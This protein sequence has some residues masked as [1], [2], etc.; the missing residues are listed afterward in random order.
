M[1]FD[2]D[3]AEPLTDKGGFNP[4][5]AEPWTE[6]ASFNPD[7]AEAWKDPAPKPKKQ[8]YEVGEEAP[9]MEPGEAA[10]M[11]DTFRG[12]GTEGSFA[13]RRLT[14]AL[15]DTM[16]PRVTLPEAP[17]G[18]PE[19]TM[20]G[21]VLPMDVEAGVYNAAKGAPEAL[22]APIG[23][24]L[25]PLQ[26]V[27]GGSVAAQVI[28]KAAEVYFA[29][30]MAQ[31]GG[32]EA[33]E[34]VEAMKDP[35][36]SRQE[37]LEAGGRAV[38]SLGLATG[39]AAHAGAPEHGALVETAGEASGEARMPTIEP[40]GPKAPKESFNPD[41]AEPLKSV[42]PIKVSPDLNAA[43]ETAAEASFNPETAKPLK[44][45]NPLA[46]FNRYQQ[47]D[48]RMRE[49]V[50][51]GETQT[52]EFR[53]LWRENEDIKNRNSSDRGNPPEA[54]E[55]PKTERQAELLND[56]T[57]FNLAGAEETAP[58]EVA[59][60][61]QAELL[62][63]G[64]GR[65]MAPTAMD[66]RNA[67]AREQP[68]EP[69]EL[70]MSGET[71]PPVG[72][73]LTAVDR[74][75]MRAE[76]GNGTPD[77]GPE[78]L[79]WI[80][81]KLPRPEDE[82]TLNGE[83][84]GIWDNLLKEREVAEKKANVEDKR[85]RKGFKQTDAGEATRF[86]AKKGG[87]ADLDRLR[88]AANEAGFNFETPADMLAAVDASMRGN[89]IYANAGE[90]GGSPIAHQEG[91]A[92]NVPKSEGK[93]LDA[94]KSRADAARERLTKKFKSGRV[95]AGI[96]PTDLKDMAEIGA[97]HLARGVTDAAQ[98]SAAMIKEFGEKI[99]P[100]LPIIRKAAEKTHA[101]SDPSAATNYGIAARV[102]A[103]R[104]EGGH[105]APVEPGLVSEPEQIV[106]RG[107]MLLESGHDPVE[108][109]QRFHQ[110]KA[111][112]ADDI[113]IVRA[114][115]EELA[116]AANTA[117]DKHGV[118][119]AEYDAAAKADSDWVAAIKPMQTAWAE[120]GRAQQGETEIDTGTFHGLRRS[121][122]EDTGK[123]FTPKQAGEAIKVARKVKDATDA[124]DAASKEL[125][126][127]IKKETAKLPKGEPSPE[128]FSLAERISI[129]LEK[130]GDAALARIK[131]RLNG[132]LF[133]TPLDPE[134]AA[135]MI[136]LGTSKIAKG[137]LDFARW[138]AE[139]VRDVG[140]GIKPHLKELWDKANREIDRE[141]SRIVK[142]ERRSAVK[143]ALTRPREERKAKA[144]GFK[145]S[146]LI[147]EKGNLQEESRQIG[148]PGVEQRPLT[149]DNPLRQTGE[150]VG[151]AEEQGKQAALPG[152]E[153]PAVRPDVATRRAGEVVGDAREQA[154]QTKLPIK[155]AR[156]TP[157]D[158]WSLAKQYIDEG[159]T[160]FESMRHKIA[161]D[162][163]IP[164]EEVTHE[165]A[166]PKDLARMTNEMYEKLS[167]RRNA[168]DDA[169]NFLKEQ[170]TPGWE[171]VIRA[172][173]RVF[174]A[175]K[176]FGHG[177]VGMITHAGLNIFDPTAWRVYW[178]NFFRQ[179]KLLGW[180]DKGAFHERMMQDLVRDENFTLARRSGLANDPR[181]Y[182]DDY[183]STWLGKYLNRIGLTG[184]RGFD[185]LKLYRQ[186]RF[187]QIWDQMPDSLK[188]PDMAKLI[189]DEV[190]HATGVVRMR[191]R[192]WANWTFFAPKLE[193]SR[194]AWMVG[195]P[196]KAA[197]VLGNW[198]DATP[199]EK[200]FAMREVRQKAIIAGTYIGLLAANQ[201][202]L[203]MVG[204][205]QSINYTNP[206]RGDFL[207]FKVGGYNF[208]VVGPMLG[209]VRLFANL[210]H[211]SFG[212]RTPFEQAAASRSGQSAKVA[213]DY[214]R[215]KLSPFASF[216]ED[217]RTQA[218]FR[219][220]P[221]PFSKERVPASLRRQGIGAY[222][223]GEYAAEQFS[224]IPVSEAVKEIWA[225]QGMDESTAEHW[226]D[227]LV[228][229][230]VMGST[231]AKMS[232]DA[233]I[234]EPASPPPRSP[235][236]LHRRGH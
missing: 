13:Q 99:K 217:M 229:A 210:L 231:G 106:E 34:F 115:G 207:A 146:S 209:M 140:A 124:A 94:L 100:Y 71:L 137:T 63:E 139:M 54:P 212:T 236:M 110:T 41:T 114:H 192:E 119:S 44:A 164:V 90:E 126:E 129:A 225:K 64:E 161:A 127:G 111:L 186:A 226:M 87:K 93:I 145:V 25:A 36:K 91:D 228:A 75:R 116:K 200:M 96:D 162:L 134:L 46:D 155:E 42:E 185:A 53:D 202:L 223:Y 33:A 60:E 219:G 12:R 216:A 183:Q 113:A 32:K 82:S 188:N 166:R 153:R 5:T 35:T 125:I 152:I 11:K 65:S 189:A 182:T 149:P 19:V 157:A 175:A 7:T 213:G 57:P 1:P 2:P 29:G 20:P 47:I 105:I 80:K 62:P 205:K 38:V 9:G 181:R 84:Q 37:R 232:K 168:V 148:L 83:L 73:P 150:V 131:E 89:K 191:F 187:N 59:P 95:S 17:T 158:V 174:F 69:L 45:E 122:I 26:L 102:T 92:S 78:L 167:A 136:I 79:D 86:F 178:P 195:D 97:Y 230:A 204:S 163:G 203:S 48:A 154:K 141:V 193:G 179:F 142:P 74:A 72:K 214:F 22:T 70:D 218:D 118:G 66:Q 176:V 76:E 235:P 197:R 147:P 227:A 199:E 4:A 233:H 31:A 15:E 55:L 56:E 112:S 133:S 190:N 43:Q 165:L 198:K 120:I 16:K 144:E 101:E 68:A 85:A 130:K 143:K 156:V 224:P 169:K 10:A 222:T 220:R 170:K 6:Q 160:D 138:S 208:G 58:V 51:S 135:D 81:G 109:L 28:L 23:L 201:G 61:A 128:A 103:Q 172:V 14:P 98:W 67:A 40:L 173:P 211:A 30:D 194:W 171:R 159:E 39:A 215:G 117:M 196:V 177:T 184:N 206:R 88:H 52:Q 3:T 108:V 77:T 24:V 221:L 121:F 123:D 107:R 21:H 27:R 180:H 104:A 49:L 234:G 151:N 50:A 132:R 8:V 18:L